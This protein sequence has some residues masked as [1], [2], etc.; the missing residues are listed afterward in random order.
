MIKIDNEKAKSIV[1]T[2]IIGLI[3][4]ILFEWLMENPKRWLIVLAVLIMG[5]GIAKYEGYKEEQEEIAR[6][7]E[8]CPTCPVWVGDFPD[9]HCVMN[10][11]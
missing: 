10:C 5:I 1:N 4:L 8:K 9:Y 2:V 6:S 11:P 3:L 7:L